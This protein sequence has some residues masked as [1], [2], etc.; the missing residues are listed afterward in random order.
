MIPI[1]FIWMCGDTDTIVTEPFV[2]FLP[3]FLQNPETL[4]QKTESEGA[5]KVKHQQTGRKLQHLNLSILSRNIVFV[6]DELAFLVGGGDEE[7]R[8]RN[9]IR[10]YLFTV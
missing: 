7:R 1:H 8:S 2:Y 9:S 6:V 3:Q 10:K 5:S 4:G